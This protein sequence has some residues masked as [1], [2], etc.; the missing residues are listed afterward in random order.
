MNTNGMRVLF[1][2]ALALGFFFG[3]KSAGT[4]QSSPYV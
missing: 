4:K 2:F 1:L 3:R